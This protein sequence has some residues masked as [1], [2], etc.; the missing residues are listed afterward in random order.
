MVTVKK[1]Q[2][3]PNALHCLLQAADLIR[4]HDREPCPGNRRNQGERPHVAEDDIPLL[5]VQVKIHP[6]VCQ[7][8][9]RMSQAV[10][11]LPRIPGMGMP[12]V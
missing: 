5:P 1:R 10:K 3:Q 2:M 8:S 4:P 11:V 9:F 6:G 12:V 7:R